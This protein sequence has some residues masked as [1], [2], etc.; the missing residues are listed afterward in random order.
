MS[1]VERTN[2]VDVCC[3]TKCRYS[4]P[5]PLHW[6]LWI[7]EGICFAPAVVRYETTGQMADVHSSPRHSHMAGVTV[8]L[9]CLHFWGPPWPP[10]EL[11]RYVPTYCFNGCDTWTMLSARTLYLN[12][13]LCYMSPVLSEHS[14]TSYQTHQKGL[15]ALMFPL[16]KETIPSFPFSPSWF[17]SPTSRFRTPVPLSLHPPFNIS[18]AAWLMWPT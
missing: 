2:A 13:Y 11:D 9:H 17:Y 18:F 7:I 3:E 10:W 12:F 6:L 4:N 16:L 14:K 5:G 8:A 1:H 15:R